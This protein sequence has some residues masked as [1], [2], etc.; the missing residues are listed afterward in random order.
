MA[1]FK[2]SVVQILICFHKVINWFKREKI[3]TTEKG[4]HVRWIMS[5]ITLFYF[6]GCWARM[7]ENWFEIIAINF[8][9]S[10]S[11]SKIIKLFLS[12]FI[13]YSSNFKRVVFRPLIYLCEVQFNVF[14]RTSIS[15]FTVQFSTSTIVCHCSSSIQIVCIELQQN[16][17]IANLNEP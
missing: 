6:N 15:C 10:G 1:F 11:S 5:S 13:L 8:L 12:F 9:K 3:C 2:C 4:I 14:Y 7:F 17:F 16:S